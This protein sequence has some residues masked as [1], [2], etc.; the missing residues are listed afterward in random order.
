M[1]VLNGKLANCHEWELPNSQNISMKHRSLLSLWCCVNMSRA[2][3]RPPPSACWGR[4]KSLKKQPQK[5]KH[6]SMRVHGMS[7]LVQGSFGVS[8]EGDA[9]SISDTDSHS[10]ETGGWGVPHSLSFQRCPARHWT[11]RVVRATGIC[12]QGILEHMT[13][14]EGSV[15]FFV[16]NMKQKVLRLWF[17]VF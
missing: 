7:Y 10:S 1:I 2:F 13:T 3:P 14:T 11:G 15:G 6:E 9:V 4:L 16:V 5:L 8:E 12:F 17:W